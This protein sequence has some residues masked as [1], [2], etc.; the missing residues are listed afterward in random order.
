MQHNQ[1]LFLCTVLAGRQVVIVYHYS[2]SAVAAPVAV[3]PVSAS[4]CCALPSS[5]RFL[6]IFVLRICLSFADDVSGDRLVRTRP[7]SDYNCRLPITDNLQQ[8]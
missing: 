7:I 8:V 2:T 1:P 5:T 4:A 6:W 3:A